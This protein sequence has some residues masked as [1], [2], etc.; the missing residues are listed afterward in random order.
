[1]QKPK[2]Y[3]YYALIINIIVVNILISIQHHLGGDLQCNLIIWHDGTYFLAIII[4]IIIF[5]LLFW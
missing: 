2:H 1:M 4:G 5:A 3:Y